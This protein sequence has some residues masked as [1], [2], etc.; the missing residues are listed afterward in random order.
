MHGSLAA[1][2]IDVCSMQFDNDKVVW[3]SW[4][5]AQAESVPNLPN[6]ND[7][8]GSFV[9]VGARIHLYAYLDKLDRWAVYCD[10]NSVIYV[11]PRQQYR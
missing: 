8:I 7:V 2:E 10:T 4:R 6:T 9:T 11:K 3:I 1:V 5:Y